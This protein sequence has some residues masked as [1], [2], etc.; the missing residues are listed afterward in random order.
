MKAMELS[1]PGTKLF[2]INYKDDNPKVFNWTDFIR[3][4]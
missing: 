1:T 3:D 4:G 2:S